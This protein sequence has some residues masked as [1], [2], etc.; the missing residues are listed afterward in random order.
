[1]IE[2]IE[3]QIRQR[4]DVLAGQDPICNRLMG[5]LDIIREQEKTDESPE[6]SIESE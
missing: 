4:M 2:E 5:R 1:M 6:L 3:A